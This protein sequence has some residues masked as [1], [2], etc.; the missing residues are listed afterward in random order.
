MSHAVIVYL[1]LK[2]RGFGSENEREALFA[3]QDQPQAAL[4]QTNAGELDGDLWG[5]G[6]C[7]VY[8]YGPNADHLFEVIEPLLRACGQAQG[9]Y[10]LKQ[11]GDA[12]D[13]NAREVRVAW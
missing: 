2:D 4:E 10:A 6:E 3:L 1:R 7:I 11:Y 13:W 8:L 12:D 9:G 5:E